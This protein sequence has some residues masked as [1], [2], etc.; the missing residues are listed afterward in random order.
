MSEVNQFCCAIV[1][2]TNT[3]TNSAKIHLRNNNRNLINVT[4]KR[5]FVFL[6]NQ[7]RNEE[8]HTHCCEIDSWEHILKH[9]SHELHLHTLSTKII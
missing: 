4:E 6:Q 7:E 3:T 8:N 1:I 5:R 2:Q 9:G